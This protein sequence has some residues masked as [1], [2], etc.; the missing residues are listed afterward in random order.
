ML[1]SSREAK[2]TKLF[3]ELSALVKKVEDLYYQNSAN[4]II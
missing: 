2:L 1:I 3:E 4:E